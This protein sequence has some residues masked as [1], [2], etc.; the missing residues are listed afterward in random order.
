[1]RAVACCMKIWGSFPGG[2]RG[3]ATR[4]NNTPGRFVIPGRR[5]AALGLRLGAGLRPGPIGDREPV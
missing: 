3:G 2:A 4:H 1:M 5:L